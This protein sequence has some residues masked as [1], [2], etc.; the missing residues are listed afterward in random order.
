LSSRRSLFIGMGIFL[1]IGF[2][3][4][5]IGNSEKY[6]TGHFNVDLARIHTLYSILNMPC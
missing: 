3:C 1:F 5:P 2:L 4:I 6:R